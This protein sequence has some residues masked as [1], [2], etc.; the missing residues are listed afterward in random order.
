MKRFVIPIILL[1][2][3]GFILFGL[4]TPI[5]SGVSAAKAEKQKLA[6]GLNN[7]KEIQ[8]QLDTL[9]Q[10]FNKLS[11][12]DL[13]SIDRLI[14]DTIDNVKLVIDINEIASNYGMTIKNI[15]IQSEERESGRSSVS[16]TEADSAQTALAG[17]GSMQVGSIL[18]G[19]SVEGSYRAFQLF[20]RDLSR[21]LRLVDIESLK[22]N[23]NENDFYQ[24]D[25][26]LRTY[27]LK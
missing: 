22:F 7:A 21:S 12:N 6:E 11:Q 8:K 14:P 4:S 17:A 27:W 18:I 9:L 5:M 13:D 20:L 24:Y 23:G 10:E 15:T 1:I 25:V 26:V 2:L 3:S 19:F 16:E